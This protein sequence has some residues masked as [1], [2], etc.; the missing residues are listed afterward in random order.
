MQQPQEEQQH[1]D[2]PRAADREGE[3]SQAKKH[4]PY[5][6]LGEDRNEGIPGRNNKG[7][8]PIIYQQEI[9]E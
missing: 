9:G 2:A 5:K 7:N 6:P 3:T 8:G 4:D 1:H